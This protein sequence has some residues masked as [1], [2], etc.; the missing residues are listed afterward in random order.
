ME[1]LRLPPELDFIA[2]NGT[3]PNDPVYTPAGDCWTPATII[4]KTTTPPSYTVRTT[5]AMDMHTIETPEISKHL[6]YRHRGQLKM[7]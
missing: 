1:H 5:N 3:K 7:Q 6:E 2:N 4:Q